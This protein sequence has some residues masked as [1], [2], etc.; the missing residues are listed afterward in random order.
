MTS[1]LETTKLLNEVVLLKG[2]NQ[3]LLLS[4]IFSVLIAFPS[5]AQFE[6]LKVVGHYLNPTFELEGKE[7]SKKEVRN[8]LTRSC[9]DAVPVFNKSNNK[10]YVAYT[11]GAIGLSILC[12]EFI[13]FRDEQKRQPSLGTLSALSFATGAI[14]FEMSS[15][16]GFFRTA[17]IYDA[18]CRNREPVVL[19]FGVTSSNG[20]GLNLKF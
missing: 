20:L 3:R 17:S 13:D 18:Q 5:F 7:I 19:N 12:I 6:E 11:L 10:Q 16:K 4:L 2:K 1:N 9:P 8:F 14:L 15:R